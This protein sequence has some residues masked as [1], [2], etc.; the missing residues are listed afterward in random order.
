MSHFILIPNAIQQIDKKCKLDEI[1]AYGLIRSQI[2][3]DSYTASISQEELA[4]IG[5]WGKSTVA[6]YIRDLIK[7]GLMTQGDS[8]K[9]KNGDHR[10]NVYQFG[11]LET[12]YAI[13]DPFFFMDPGLTS[14]QKGL[15]MLLKSHCYYGTN[16]LSYP[17][18]SKIGELLGIGSESLKKKVRELIDIGQ[19][20]MIGDTLVLLNPHI[21]HAL[22][23]RISTNWVYSVIYEF[24]V[25]KGVVPPRK[26]VVGKE[27]LRR[28][29]AKYGDRDSLQKG[30]QERFK[31][32]PPLVN[33]A[34]FT[35]GLM[36]EHYDTT[37][38][39]RKCPYRDYSLHTTPFTFKL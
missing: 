1:C 19:A 21:K 2:T 39:K 20:K 34:Y 16:H 37:A 17:S 22:D 5:G 28:I 27:N 24:C 6:N 10:Y 15:I 9:C 26:N 3:D 12:N 25:E 18:D 29:A 33:I 14:E 4:S 36:G 31:T 38:Q 7:L 35:Q 32:L 11:K 8:E 23:M 13:Y 30:L